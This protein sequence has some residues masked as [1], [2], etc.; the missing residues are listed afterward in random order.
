MAAHKRDPAI[1]RSFDDPS[2]R[3]RDVRHEAARCKRRAEVTTE[4]VEERQALERWRR[5]DDE[6]RA[7]DGRGAVGRRDIARRDGPSGGP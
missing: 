3:A 2:L 1:A 5:E 4:V 6:I 7:L